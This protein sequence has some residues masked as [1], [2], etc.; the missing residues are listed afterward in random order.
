MIFPPYSESFGRKNLYIVSTVLYAI[1][2]ALIASVPKLPM[3]ILGRFFTGVFSSIPTI[4]V[5]GSIE[6]LY[7][8]ISRVWMVF[9]WLTVANLGLVVGTIAGTYITFGIGW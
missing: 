2:C 1:F 9:A 3:I 5:A 4:V 6:D 7:D 8:T